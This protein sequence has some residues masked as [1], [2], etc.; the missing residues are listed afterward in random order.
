[1]IRHSQLR[2]DPNFAHQ[3]VDA[4]SAVLSTEPQT[5][6]T[7]WSLVISEVQQN[8]QLKQSLRLISQN[9]RTLSWSRS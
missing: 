3:G 7:A 8:V 2:S 9:S 5:I 1:M 4:C 6:A